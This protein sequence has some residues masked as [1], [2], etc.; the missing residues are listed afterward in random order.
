MGFNSGLK[1]LTCLV[2]SLFPHFQFM[3]RVDSK[4]LVNAF[5]VSGNFCPINKEQLQ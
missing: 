2:I 1:E 5:H 3:R 4:L